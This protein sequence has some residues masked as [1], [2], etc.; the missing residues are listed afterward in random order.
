MDITFFEVL[1]LSKFGN[2][3]VLYTLLTEPFPQ[4]DVCTNVVTVIIPFDHI[5][6]TLQS[7]TMKVRLRILPDGSICEADVSLHEYFSIC[8]LYKWKKSF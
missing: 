6:P 7:F 3:V 8:L 1:P 5:N 2:V 4:I